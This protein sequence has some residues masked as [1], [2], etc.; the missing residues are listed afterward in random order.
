MRIGTSE[1]VTIFLKNERGVELSGSSDDELCCWPH[2]VQQRRA[3]S[4][5][6]ERLSRA[7]VSTEDIVARNTSPAEAA[8]DRLHL[9]RF[10]AR[11]RRRHSITHSS[12][13]QL[14]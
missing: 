7:A 13:N 10:D 9:H 5:T 2:R 1:Q 14:L 3:R 11:H 8:V 12:R 4:H 6:G